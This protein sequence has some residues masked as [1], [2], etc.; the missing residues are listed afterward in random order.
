MTAI[1]NSAS[2]PKAHKSI[3]HYYNV[4]KSVEWQLE[5]LPWGQIPYVRE[6]KGSPEKVA[7]RRDF[8]RNVVMQ[9]LQADRHASNMAAQLL[10]STPTHHGEALLYYTTLVQD[11]VKHTVAWQE[12]INQLGGDG[13]INPYLDKLCGMVLGA[14]TLEEKIFMM[15]VFFERLIIP[16]FKDIRDISKGTLL[17]ELTDRLIIDDTI[18]HMSGVAFERELLAAASKKQKAK[19]VKTAGMALSVYVQFE[20]WRPSQRQDLL[21]DRMRARDQ[22]RILKNVHDGKKTGAELGLDFSEVSDPDFSEPETPFSV[23][24]TLPSRQ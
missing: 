5:D 21:G 19:V 6:A 9:Q 22:E 18:H 4:A 8:W 14:D 13:E 23:S 24:M 12:L 7:Q 3:G 16:K 20:Q 10:T 17:A 15:Q 11:E 2:E 1:E